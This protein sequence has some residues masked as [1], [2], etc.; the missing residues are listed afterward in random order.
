MKVKQLIILGIIVVILG[1]VL[2]MKKHRPVREV[3]VQEYAAFDFLSSLEEI[4]RL[5]IYKGEGQSDSII[6]AKVKDKWLLESFYNVG[7]RKE[8]MDALLEMFTTSK[9]ELRSR[10][11]SNL[12][13]FWIDDKRGL[14][15]EVQT[16]DNQKSH[17]IVGLK[18][19]GYRGGF[20]RESGSASTYLVD[21]NI[22]SK[23]GIWEDKE[24]AE[25]KSDFFLDLVFLDF[26]ANNVI[27][28][29]VNRIDD[30]NA[31]VGVYSSTDENS[32]Q[33]RWMFKR[34]DLP[35]DIDAAKVK[36]YLKDIR[37]KSG[38]EIVVVDPATDYGFSNPE[39]E[40]TVEV[41]QSPKRII[42]GKFLNEEAKQQRYLQ[43]A[44]APIAYVVSSHVLDM[45]NKDDSY[46]FIDNPLRI[47]SERVEYLTVETQ[48]K[49]N[50]FLQREEES[51]KKWFLEGQNES[52]SDDQI[53][54]VIDV[55][56]KFKVEE[57]MFDEKEV[58][59][60][61]ISQFSIKQQGK[62]EVFIDVYPPVEGQSVKIYPAQRRGDAVYFV[63]SEQTYQDIFANL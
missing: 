29:S 44:G 19:A 41:N 34:K 48:E 22:L 3:E 5:T 18:K 17:I 10:S 54:K 6:L 49:K 14:H 43:V 9:G 36:K 35:F 59:K 2:I 4:S 24:N 52:L 57:L 31:A 21:D 11:K 27:S 30:D 53:N 28:F 37:K 12:P 39:W 13:D 7:V 8:R 40:L 23:F 61:S 20:I 51:G 63:I 47:E 45:I 25:L 46:F 26:D 1:A 42:V 55:L 56:K 60:K 32:G 62:E 16:P 50:K 58:G 38:S 33:R 15:I